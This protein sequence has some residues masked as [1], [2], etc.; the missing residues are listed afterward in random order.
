MVGAERVGRLLEDE[1]TVGEHVAAVGNGE[2]DLDVLLHQQ[3]GAAALPGVRGDHREESLDDHGGEPERE[4][5]EQQQPRPAGERPPERQHLLLAAREQSDAAVGELGK[6]REVA[7]GDC[8]RRGALPGTRFESARRPSYR[9][10]RPGPRARG[11]CRDG[12]GRWATAQR[13]R[14]RRPGSPRPSAGRA[15]DRR[16]VVVLPAPLGPSRATTSPAPTCRSRSRT[17]AAAS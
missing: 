2:R 12:L 9:R 10:T 8:Q 5:V 4:L 7:E 1:L 14:P 6:R 17:T 13:C 3:H 15:G 11:R 16:S